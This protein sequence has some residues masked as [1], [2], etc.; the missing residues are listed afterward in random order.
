MTEGRTGLRIK[1]LALLVVFMFVALTTRLWFLQVMATERY[2]KQASQNAVRLVQI[3]APRGR[4]LDA[5]AIPMVDNQPS[6]QVVVDRG[7]VAGH[8]EQVLFALSNVLKGISV[9]SLAKRLESKKYLPYAPVPVAFNV[10]KEVAFAI[11]EY[12]ERFQGV[13]V[14]QVPARQYMYGDLGAHILGFIGP[15]ND[16]QYGTPEYAGYGSNDMV[17]QAGLEKQY[18]PFL[19]GQKGATKLRID[20]TGKVLGELGTVTPPV[21]GNDLRLNIDLA[22][23]QTA[24]VSLQKGIERA[25][26]AGYPA[27]SGS[28]VVLDPT[29]GAVKAIAS[30]P[31][32]NPSVFNGGLS[33]EEMVNLGM[34]DRKSYRGPL[35]HTWQAAQTSRPLT[36]RAMDGEYPPGSTIKP[37]VALSALREGFA[38]ETQRFG[39]PGTFSVP[40]DLPGNVWHNWTSADLGYLTLREAIIKSCDTVFYHLGY[41]SYWSSYTWPSWPTPLPEGQAPKELMQR[42]FGSFG[43]GQPPGIDFPSSSQGLVPDQAWK[44]ATY[45][46]MIN[47]NKQGVYCEWNWCPGDYINMAIGQGNMRVT[48]LQLA[49]AFSVIASDGKLCQPRLAADA[50]RPGG[51][52]VEAF[53]PSCHQVPN[54]S[55]QQF[56]YIRS[57]LE[58]VPRP[59]GTAAAAFIGFPFGS[60]DF[61]GGKT[62]TAE[63]PNTSQ[64]TAWFGSIAKGQDS[65][66]VSHSYVV[67]AMIER[68]GHGSETA[69]PVVRQVVDGLF[70][71]NDIANL[72]LGTKAD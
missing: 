15:I 20:A 62:G 19:H 42:D 50:E 24:E 47:T 2:R 64:T 5:N 18:E 68:A 40:G 72:H 14:E 13:T 16:T 51:K 9:S 11:G 43:F 33:P 55:G 56:K 57:A 46:P 38:T 31:T 59:G 37:F 39:C 54:Y 27:I 8:E 58:G 17:G 22:A 26:A 65:K 35:L 71:L 12:P 61:F 10:S 52:V 29:D 70:D 7:E 28:V 6:L 49:M 48:P 34:G 21:S 4:I 63:M 67:V 44:Q 53:Q 23:Q 45:G 69:A 66:G 30:S 32:F 41:Y 1:V 3:P 36:N 25:Q 60:L